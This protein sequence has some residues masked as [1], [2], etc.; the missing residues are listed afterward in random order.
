MNT[1]LFKY[2]DRL[3]HADRLIRQESTGRPRDFA[4]KLNISE[5]HLYGF[6][7]E[8]KTMGL[9]LVYSK[10]KHTYYYSIPVRLRIEIEIERETT[11]QSR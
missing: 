10:N 8:L 1:Q 11:G 7:E 5:S 2:T 3:K 9:P 4:R 6:L